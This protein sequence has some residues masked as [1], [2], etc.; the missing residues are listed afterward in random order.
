[1]L[2]L[3]LATETLDVTL[4][5]KKN[6]IG[7]RHPLT[8]VLDELKEIVIGMGFEI[9]RVPRSSWTTTTSKH[10]ISQ[11]TIRPATPRTPSTSTTTLF[12][13]HRPPQSQ[14]R[15]MENQKPPIRVLAPGRVYRVRRGGCHPL[16][17]VPSGR[18]P[19]MVDK[20]ITYGRPEGYPGG[21]C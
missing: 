11:R 12:C 8:V 2:D 18:R 1:M 17:S 10:S 5:G 9:A 21:V 13:E 19:L 16:P 20:G 7:K 15:V 14:I 6:V 4:P 3:R